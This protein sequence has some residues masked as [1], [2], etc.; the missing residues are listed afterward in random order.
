LQ[1]ASNQQ[2]TIRYQVGS[3]LASHP[4]FQIPWRHQVEIFS[5]CKSIKEA[6]F[7]VQKTIDN[8]WSRAVLMHFTEA[9]QIN[10]KNEFEEYHEEHQ[11]VFLFVFY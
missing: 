3:E 8:G 5:K 6:M 11:N 7:Y 1:Q 4:I 2:S 10:A 9:A